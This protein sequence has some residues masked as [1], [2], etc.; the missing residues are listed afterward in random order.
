M[1]DIDLP[2]RRRARGNA[3]RQAIYDFVSSY[4]IEHNRI[5]NYREIA[6]GV[7]LSISTI[8]HHLHALREHGHITF[9]SGCP[10]TLRLTGEA[11]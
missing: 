6:E 3:S 11:S 5:P 9:E 4:I 1:S 10:R 2:G 8:K 7:N